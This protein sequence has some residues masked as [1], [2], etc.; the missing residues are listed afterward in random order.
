MSRWKRVLPE[1]LR[2]P[3]VKD[4]ASQLRLFLENRNIEYVERP[5]RSSRSLYFVFS[6][7]ET[8]LCV[9]ISDH[10]AAKNRD[11]PPD[12]DEELRKF[13]F[14]DISVS[15]QGKATMQSVRTIVRK[16][17]KKNSKKKV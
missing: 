6:I 1:K 8:Q 12:I 16:L 17:I 15:P 3:F 13:Y 11:I 14:P 10:P 7:G 5:S 2:S 9:R 4:N